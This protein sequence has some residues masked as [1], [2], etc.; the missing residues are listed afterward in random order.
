E[1]DSSAPNDRIVHSLME[2]EAVRLILG[3]PTVVLDRLGLESWR[4][5]ALINGVRQQQIIG[6]IIVTPHHGEFSTF[7]RDLLDRFAEYIR[8]RVVDF[9]RQWKRLSLCFSP[10]IVK[11]VLQHDDFHNRILTPR[12]ADAAVLF[13][14][15]AG[16]TTLSEQLH[17]AD[18][19]RL[20]DTWADEVVAVLDR[21]RVV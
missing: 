8:L 19:G 9:N 6:R 3:Q 15:I 20:I 7:D 21:K 17:P 12:E 1:H 18:I 11:R 2:A 4:E 14:D 16:F 5:E 10:P 13:V